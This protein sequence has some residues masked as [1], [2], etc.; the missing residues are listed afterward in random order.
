M[1]KNCWDFKNCGRGPGNNGSTCPAASEMRLDGVHGGKNGGRACW[2][3]AGTF[4]GGIV[5]GSFA[6]K[7]ETCEKC[8][9]YRSVKEDEKPQFQLSAVLLSRMR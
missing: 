5:Q 6:R 1:N 3:V 9:F 4:C 2:I 7:Y 8:D